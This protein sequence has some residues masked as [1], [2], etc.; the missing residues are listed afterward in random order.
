MLIDVTFEKGKKIAIDE[1]VAN[2]MPELRAV[3]QKD[4]QGVDAIAIIAY[5][6]DPLSPVREA[7]NGKE[8]RILKEAYRAVKRDDSD[9]DR[10]KFYKVKAIRDAM[11]VYT[12][13][14]NTPTAQNITKSREMV[15]QAISDLH[16][17]VT[18]GLKVGEK[19]IE[20]EKGDMSI[21]EMI[22]SIKELPDMIKNDIAM[23]D[24]QKKDVADVKIK[25]KGETPLTRGEFRVIQRT[26]T[27]K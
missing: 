18:G 4:N 3:L 2:C 23:K 12:D 21:S 19:G 22:K 17:I 16:D 8:D 20:T 14:C 24:I 1:N 7:F 6:C 5:A 27:K 15:Y 11:D 26:S 9:S 25:I 10:E 13:W